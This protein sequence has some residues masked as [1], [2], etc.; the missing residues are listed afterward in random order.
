MNMDYVLNFIKVLG[1]K[2][3]KNILNVWEVR[4]PVEKVNKLQYNLNAD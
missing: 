1:L 3:K 4:N 2:K